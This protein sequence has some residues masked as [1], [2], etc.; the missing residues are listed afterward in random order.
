MCVVLCSCWLSLDPC[1]LAPVF[2]E[3]VNKFQ[4]VL[5]QAA[6]NAH[7]A[8]SP[9]LD[10]TPSPPFNVSPAEFASK[11]FSLSSGGYVT[12]TSSVASSVA[13][14]TPPSSIPGSGSATPSQIATPPAPMLTQSPS[15]RSKFNKFACV[16]IATGRP[17]SV[18]IQT[19]PTP[20]SDSGSFNP[21]SLLVS[22]NGA[23]SFL[24]CYPVNTGPG[25]SPGPVAVPIPA[26]MAGGKGGTIRSLAPKPLSEERHSAQENKDCSPPKRA[27]FS[28]TLTN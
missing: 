2:S 26:P 15:P 12:T 16:E 19:R 20:Y 9:K 4:S 6:A 24:P 13:G 8:P 21:N 1:S 25:P 27:C 5:E 22:T 28:P 17:G 11:I 3:F 23:R 14:G 10:A 7:S 18:S